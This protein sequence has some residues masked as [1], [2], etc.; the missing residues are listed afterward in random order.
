MTTKGK[1]GVCR[2][3]DLVQ[4][5][6]EGERAVRAGEKKKRKLIVGFLSV[7]QTVLAT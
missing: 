4:Q 6:L 1:D 7:W 2:I 3:T 5:T